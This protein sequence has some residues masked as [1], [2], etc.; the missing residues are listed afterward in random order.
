MVEKLSFGGK[1]F[2]GTR[3]KLLSRDNRRDGLGLKLID[4]P[5]PLNHSPMGPIMDSSFVPLT[6][7]P[8]YQ[9]ALVSMSIV[10]SEAHEAPFTQDDKPGREFSVL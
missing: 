10:D 8:N 4:E 7:G 1:D 3:D 9:W 6:N 2:G 5:N